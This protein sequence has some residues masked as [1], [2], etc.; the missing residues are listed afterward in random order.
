[1]FIDEHRDRFGV[2]P[3]CRA[4]GL[5]TSTYYARK[6]RPPSQ[7][8]AD[9]ARLLE[10]IRHIHADNYRA[11]GARRVWKALRRQGVGVG[12]G[13]VER[14]MRTAGLQGAGTPKRRWTT[15]PDEHAQRPAD[16]VDR[17]F[18]A[19]AP[20]QLW[21]C[22]L[23]YLKTREGFVY[24]AFVKDVYSRMIVGWQTSTNLRTDLVLDALEMAAA[25]RKPDPASGLIHHSDR[26]SQYTSFRYTQRL[27]DL[28]ITASVGSVADAYDNAMAESFVAT[29]K[30]ELVQGRVFASRFE[31]EIAVFEY[32]GW[33][34]HRRLHSELGDRPPSEFEGHRER[35]NEKTE[36]ID[37]VPSS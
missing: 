3:I 10:Q 13:R 30:R 11:Y 5:A 37:Y 34:N 28:G 17:H 25:A 33:F 2:E 35:E 16:L 26:G 19:S 7:R 23:T 18:T 6:N 22:D 15:I 14:L 21:V 32:L 1:M 36:G 4:L 20:D 12:R 9:D 27:A 8:S 31:A 24:L 29:L